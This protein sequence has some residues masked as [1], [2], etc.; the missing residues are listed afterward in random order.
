MKLDPYQLF[1]ICACI[2]FGLAIFLWKLI[3]VFKMGHIVA[4][5]MYSL[6]TDQSKRRGPYIYT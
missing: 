1:L 2:N 6:I 4:V 3:L 5:F